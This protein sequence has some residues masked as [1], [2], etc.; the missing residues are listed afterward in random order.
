MG[1]KL[2]IYKLRELRGIPQVY[3][4]LQIA[5]DGSW[6]AKFSGR[7][8]LHNTQLLQ[9]VPEFLLMPAAVVDVVKRLDATVCKGNND[10]RF[11]DLAESRGGKF[12]NG[13]SKHS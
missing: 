1:G 11:L 8:L 6:E 10:E 7:Q 9:D 12:F 13:A 3:S 2:L 5:A 4:S